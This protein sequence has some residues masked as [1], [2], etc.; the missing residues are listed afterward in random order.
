MADFF[1][2]F[3]ENEET[4]ATEGA[5]KTLAVV[6]WAK[7]LLSKIGPNALMAV[8]T[9]RSLCFEAR[10][11]AEIHNANCNADYEYPTGMGAT[12]VDFR[13]RG[14]AEWLIEI[15]SV[16]ISEAVRR[17]TTEEGDYSSFSL[18]STN[19][20]PRSSEEGEM[21]R[22]TEKIAAK[23]QKFPPVRSNV[24]HI[25]LADMRGYLLKGGDRTDYRQMAYGPSD[26]PPQFIHHWEGRP[27]RGLFERENPLTLAK[28]IQERIHFL[29]FGRERHYATGELRDSRAV[30]YLP[31]PHL[32]SQQQAL[33]A[34]SIYPVK[35]LSNTK[36]NAP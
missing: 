22:A 8:R 4:L 26:V 34:Y 11:A 6:G 5:L 18:S 36:P 27:I 29:G 1:R 7:P 23:V 3:H 16:D 35:A 25:I 28:Q 33:A 14:P 19:T 32:M 30:Y 9:K 10:F 17:A 24:Y 13:V 31:N 2:N 15:V 21:V 20:D 12:S